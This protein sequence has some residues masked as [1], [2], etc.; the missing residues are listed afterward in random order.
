MHVNFFLFVYH[1]WGCAKSKLKSKDQSFVLVA[2]TEN[3]I[4]LIAVKLNESRGFVMQ[5]NCVFASHGDY[6]VKGDGN[7]L[8]HS[9]IRFCVNDSAFLNCFF[10]IKQG[11][12]LLAHTVIASWE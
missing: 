7:I 10:L 8:L 9:A 6:G 5:I 12:S 4:P 1:I 3:K 2:E 11:F